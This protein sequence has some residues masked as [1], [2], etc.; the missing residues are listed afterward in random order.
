MSDLHYVNIS[1]SRTWPPFRASL[2]RPAW[3]HQAY[4][5]P[6][7]WMLPV[8]KSFNF[9]QNSC[10]NTPEGLVL[11]RVFERMRLRTW[12][13]ISS[14][15][16]NETSWT[17]WGSPQSFH[18]KKAGGKCVWWWACPVLS[19]QRGQVVRLVMWSLHEPTYSTHCHQRA[20]LTM[21]W[22]Q[23]AQRLCFSLVI[24]FKTLYTFLKCCFHMHMIKHTC[25]HTHAYLYLDICTRVRPVRYP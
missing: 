8:N 10:I 13:C 14:I 20:S 24:G 2:D 16:A 12:I 11:H 22:M 19:K 18:N 7:L 3:V 1:V 5:Q 15:T 23:Q 17:R 25:T 21:F 9:R 4:S 6:L